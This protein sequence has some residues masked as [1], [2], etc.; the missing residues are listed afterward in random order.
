[1]NDP[2]RQAQIPAPENPTAINHSAPMINRNRGSFWQTSALAICGIIVFT[3]LVELSAKWFQIT[4]SGS[5]MLIA[6]IALTAVP[7]LLWLTAFYL[8]DRD[9]PEPRRYV[10]GILLLGGFLALTVAIP[11]TRNVFRVQEWT[12]LTPWYMQLLCAIFTV[13][14]IQEFCK[15]AAVRYTIYFNAAFDERIDGIIYGA[16]A[17]LG[18]GSVLAIEHLVQAGGAQLSTAAIRIAITTLA[19]ASFGGITGYF[20]GRAKF[21]NMGKWWLPGGISLAAL[22]NGLVTWLLGE[23]SSQGLMLTPSS[24]LILAGATA[25]LVFIFLAYQTRRL[26]QHKAD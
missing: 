3:V 18:F 2:N 19:Q 11:L 25:V 9:E 16:A 13:G 1:M 12:G 21:D 4:L 5:M 15:Y 17:G 20:I 6:S 14:F 10:L 8:L 22:L 23:V 7:T 26:A 24:G